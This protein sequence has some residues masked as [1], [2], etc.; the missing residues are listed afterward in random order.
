MSLAPARKYQPK[1]SSDRRGIPGTCM[2]QVYVPLFPHKMVAM[3]PPASVSIMP[4]RGFLLW[5]RAFVVTVDAGPRM[6]CAVCRSF[7]NCVYSSY[8]PFLV[9][10]CTPVFGDKA[11]KFVSNLSLFLS[12]LSPKNGTVYVGDFFFFFF[13]SFIF[14][15]VLISVTIK[16]DHAHTFQPP[17]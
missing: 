7:G 6:G 16:Y 11:V 4:T 3:V 13:L 2:L 8:D 12:N 10:T 5:P 1:G 15:F 17:A 9:Y 14:F